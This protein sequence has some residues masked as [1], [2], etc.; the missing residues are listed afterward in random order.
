MNLKIW[1]TTLSNH[2]FENLYR[3]GA[4]N[5]YVYKKRGRE[6]QPKVH[7]CP[8]RGGLEYPR[9]PKPSYFKKYSYYCIVHCNG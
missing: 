2:L 1:N 8:L 9:V 5:N 6:G 7:A 4:F 3:K